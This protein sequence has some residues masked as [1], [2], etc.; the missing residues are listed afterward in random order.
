VGVLLARP[1]VA[2][3]VG[4][5][6][7]HHV[8]SGPEEL[9][10]VYRADLAFAVTPPAFLASSAS[11][12]DGPD[13]TDWIEKGRRAYL[14]WTEKPTPQPGRFNLGAAICALRDELPA[15]AILSNGAG[16]Y[17][18]WLHRYYRH[19]SFGTQLGPTS[20][21]MGF[22]LPAAIAAKRLH[23]DR[24]VVAFAGDGCFMMTCQEFATAAQYRLGLIVVVVDNGMYGTIRMHQERHYPGRVVGTDLRNPDFAAFAAACGGYGER[25]E[26]TEDFLPAFRRAAASGQPAILHCMTDPEALTP[27]RSLSDIR[28][29]SAAVS[30]P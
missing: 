22:G 16:N 10:R 21:S 27:G 15:D 24:T 12:L 4:H 7:D 17:A 2:A 26:T 18:I 30:K 5:G 20:G 23:P 6:A 9:G 11:I 8:H 14:D 29:A 13:R 19:L 25:V 1:R 28:D 3:A